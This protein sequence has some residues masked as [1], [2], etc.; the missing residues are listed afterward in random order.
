[1]KNI[2]FR[3]PTSIR[4]IKVLW[5]EYTSKRYRKNIELMR[6]MTDFYI[7]NVLEG[8]WGEVAEGEVVKWSDSDKKQFE[9][10][11]WEKCNSY[12]HNLME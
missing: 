6:K 2:S 3:F 4:D 11:M 9:K 1:M 5:K 8:R 10:E 7:R 12:I